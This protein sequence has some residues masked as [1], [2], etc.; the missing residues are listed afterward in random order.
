MELYWPWKWNK[1]SSLLYTFKMLFLTLQ[2][3]LVYSIFM[4]F[5]YDAFQWPHFYVHIVRNCYTTMPEALNFFLIHLMC[6]H[7]CT[8]LDS[9]VNSIFHWNKGLYL[10]RSWGHQKN[11]TFFVRLMIWGCPPAGE[12]EGFQTWIN[13]VFWKFWYFYCSS[14]WDDSGRCIFRRHICTANFHS[15]FSSLQTCIW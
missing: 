1:N 7:I 15:H 13:S 10:C 12:F 14:Y 4:L 8:Y 3:Y 6:W 5:K 2:V 9:L 11:N